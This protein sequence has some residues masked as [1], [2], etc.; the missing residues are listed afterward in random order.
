ME[1]ITQSKLDLIAD[2]KA[3]AERKGWS[4]SYVSQVAVGNTALIKNVDAGK[5][6]TDKTA[7]RLTEFLRRAK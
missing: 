3:H 4:H 5:G 7:A 6:F 2:L 1:N